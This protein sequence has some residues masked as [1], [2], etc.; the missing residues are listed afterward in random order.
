ML[1]GLLIRLGKSKGSTR[2]LWGLSAIKVDVWN[3][4]ICLVAQREVGLL[5]L[6]TDIE[7]S[8]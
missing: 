8:Y 5:G 1:R 4:N 3:T 2:T 6:G 7:E